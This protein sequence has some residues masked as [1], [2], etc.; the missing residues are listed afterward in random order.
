M[1][2]IF[3]SMAGEGRGHAARVASLVEHLRRRHQL[4][5]LAPDEAYDFLA[6]KYAGP[7]FAGQVRVERI[8]GM[9]FQYTGGRLDLTKT[10]ACGLQ[11]KFA[12]RKIIRRVRNL[13][14]AEQP[15]LAISDFEPVLPRAARQ[16]GVPLL[17]LDH[18][19]FMV[20]YDLSSLSLSLRW[21]AWLM[22][23]AV[24][25]H[26]KDQVETV[27]SAFY[28]PPLRANA[29][30]VTQVGPLL[31]NEIAAAQPHNG[32]YI[33]SYLRN[34][35][36]AE[37]PEMLG[38][39]NVPVKIYGLGS[40]APVGGATFHE[41]DSQSFVRDLAGCECY[42]GAAGNQTLGEA[43]Y[44][45]KPVL[46]LPETYHHEQR[47]NAH[48]VRHMDVGDWVAL[49]KVKFSHFTNFLPQLEHYR[50]TLKSYAGQIDGTAAALEAIERNLP[51]QNLTQRELAEAAR[52]PQARL[53]DALS[54]AGS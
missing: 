32:G 9:R 54:P 45:G 13:I 14:E 30:R 20:T 6:P 48:F 29:H 35:T 28:F 5:L 27:V 22:G 25:A 39:L 3:Y 2:K 41:I 7:E 1:A 36:P 12:L 10:I 15:H 43:V 11:Y 46:A 24:R 16:S 33:L 53:Y 52:F 34:R 47:I 40:R 19:H 37:V 42:I 23:L 4:I 31:R 21:H 17:S 44:L 51:L 8:P 18:Q 26:C 38:R 49:E 50:E